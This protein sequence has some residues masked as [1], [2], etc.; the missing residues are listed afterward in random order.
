[1]A[2]RQSGGKRGHW[3]DQKKTGKSLAPDATGI[4]I[5]PI[6]RINTQRLVRKA[7]QYAIDNRRKSVTLM[8][9]GN[10]MKFTEGAFLNWGIE[11]GTK[12]FAD[13][14][15]L[16]ERL[17]KE[18]NG[19]VPEGSIVLKDR[20]ADNMFQQVLLRPEEYDVIA[21]PNLNGDYISDLLAAMIGGLGLAPGANVGSECAVFEA[22]H[23][24]A[25]KYAGK[26]KVNPGSLILSG[27]MMLDHMGWHEAAGQV[28]VALQQAIDVKQVT[29]DLARQIP[30]AAEVSCSE[31]GRQIC[32][33]MTA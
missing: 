27:A 12:E 26:D 2:G 13:H 28:R 33:F 9:K 18:F 3:S 23:G 4:G 10:I 22:T 11:V 19:K 17:W 8:H 31:F 15:I 16:E 25:P 6:S 1:M 24:T 14:V 21:A 5:K 29:Y 32:R 20:I 30:G 7:I